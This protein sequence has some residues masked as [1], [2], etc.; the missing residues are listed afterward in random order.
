MTRRQAADVDVAERHQYR[1]RGVDEAGPVECTPPGR[2]GIRVHP[3]ADDDDRADPDDEQLRYPKARDRHAAS[4][5]G[6]DRHERKQDD[7]HGRNEC[8]EQRARDDDDESG[9]HD[10]LA[11][12]QH[13]RR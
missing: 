12:G 2:V 4:Q 1:S 10:R 6:N 9:R 11:A 13:D 8:D 7:R 3:A 5:S